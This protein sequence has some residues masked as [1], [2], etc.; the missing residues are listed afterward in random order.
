M[1]HGCRVSLDNRAKLFLMKN[2]KILITLFL[3]VL[4]ISLGGWVWWGRPWDSSRSGV[5]AGTSEVAESGELIVERVIDGDTIVLSDGRTV[6][7]LGID[8]PEKGEEGFELAKQ[9]NEE[10][11]LEK[12]VRL[13]YDIERQDKYNRDLAYV[14]VEE[15][16]VNLKLIEEDFARILIIGPNLKYAEELLHATGW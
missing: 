8:T 7:Y 12:P 11:V 4:T 5:P 14:F 2:N 3:L 15:G 13:E 6:R 10:L 1:P 16:M 9:R